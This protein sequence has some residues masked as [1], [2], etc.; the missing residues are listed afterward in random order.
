LFIDVSSARKK[1]GLR[2]VFAA[3]CA[4]RAPGT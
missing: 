2:P 3:R 1:T 4:W